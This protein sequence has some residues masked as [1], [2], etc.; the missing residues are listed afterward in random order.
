[1]SVH[2]L[3][4]FAKNRDAVAAQKGYTYQQLKTLEDWIE[5]R[6]IAGEDDIY[7]DYEDDILARDIS[8]GRS[9]FT[10]IKLYSTDF[11]FSSESVKKA[12]AHFFMLFVKGEYSFDQVEF[13]FETNVSIVGRTAK[14][15][16]AALLREW[17]ENQGNISADLLQRIRIRVKKILDEYINERTEELK[18]VT[19]LKSDLQLARNIY[20]NLKDE[21]FDALIGS[22]KWQFDD[23]EAN[24]AID[25]ILGNLQELIP[26]IPLPLD[27]DKTKIYSSLLVNEVFKRSIQDDPEKRKLTNELLDSI[28]LNA[29][30]RED[31]WY[32]DIFPQ[33]KGIT[34]HDFYQGEFQTVINAANYCRWN[35]MDEGHK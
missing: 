22:I 4:I 32:A 19:E 13:R 35:F 16:D 31:K 34:V 26:R 12:I 17:H 20:T 27:S 10:Q 14:D 8:K 28:L 15:N 18:D 30:E 25:R 9:I 2:K 29:G 1:M 6:I 24:D 21:N 3:Y 5:N 23:E 7:C 11:S 33:Y